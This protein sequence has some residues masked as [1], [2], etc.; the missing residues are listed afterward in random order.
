MP[1][2]II[3]GGVPACGKS[4]I[5][6]ATK[7]VGTGKNTLVPYRPEKIR[8]FGTLHFEINEKEKC[9]FFGLYDAKMFDGRFDGTD[10]L[11]LS[12]V[13]TFMWFLKQVRRKYKGYTLVIEGDR[14]VNKLIMDKLKK[15]RKLFIVFTAT[16]SKIAKRHKKRGDGQTETYLK[17][18]STKVNNM[19]KDYPHVLLN[20][21]TKK[22]LESNTK[23][24][25]KLI[26]MDNKKFD[27][28]AE[29]AVIVE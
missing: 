4:A 12:I 25:R 10:R 17:G 29:K 24:L 3:I 28:F 7:F 1:R 16:K 26:R 21:N 14:V 11:S 18:R 8:R 13:P 9:I 27:K 20:N 19:C 22:D 23:L 5:L 6:K 15:F 2:M